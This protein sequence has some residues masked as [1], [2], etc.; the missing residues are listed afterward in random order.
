VARLLR[1][2]HRAGATLS[3]EIEQILG[4]VES[5]HPDRVSPGLPW[6][7]ATRLARWG[8]EGGGD[9]I[10]ITR[11]NAT[12]LLG[13]L[14][15]AGVPRRQAV[16]S[17]LGNGLGTLLWSRLFAQVMAFTHQSFEGGRLT[18]GGTTVVS[19][20]LNRTKFVYDMLAELEEVNLLVLDETLYH[21]AISPYYLFRR[22]LSRPGM[23]VFVGTH[24]DG[25]RRF[26][27]HLASG[28]LDGFRH[29]LVELPP[30]GG[31]GVA[32]EVVTG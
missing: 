9:A 24:H 6:P 29:P 3:I 16:V 31:A 15:A 30:S 14:L 18:D 13:A 17:T 23:V 25:L 32:Y 28:W 5:L 21:F 11:D 22:K 10:S 12:A 1:G 27:A 20:N 2:L 7:P 4:E 19:G 26:A 8:H